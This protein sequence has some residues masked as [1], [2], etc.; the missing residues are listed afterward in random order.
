M[1]LGST[2]IV[3]ACTEIRERAR[4]EA[5]TDDYDLFALAGRVDLHATASIST[6][7]PAYPTGAA[8]CEV[9][10]DPATGEVTPVRYTQIDDAGQVINPLV[11]H[12][13]TQGG[14]AQGLGQA[15]YEEMV[16][17]PL[18]GQVL[19]GSFMGYAV[20]RAH[21]LPPMAI[22]LAEDPTAGNPLRIKGGGEAGVTA[23]PAAAVNAVI[24]ALG[25]PDVEHI[26][27][28]LTAPK[29]WNILHAHGLTA[30]SNGSP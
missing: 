9:E 17:D 26:D 18:T 14:I 27:T 20:P 16:F 7:I 30:P 29:L 8:V 22:E 12:G 28:P 1:R 3:R 4:A 19:S 13:Q 23:A 24:D 2:I 15:F 10:I 5:G 25:L 21:D 11:V 6:R